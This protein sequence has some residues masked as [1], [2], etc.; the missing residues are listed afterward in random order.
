MPLRVNQ[1][2][3]FGVGR[4]GTPGSSGDAHFANVVLLCGFEGSDGST[5]LDDESASNHTLTAAGNA[6]IDTAL[7]KYGASSLLLD[8]TGDVV[9][10]PNSANFQFGSGQFTV[11]CHYRP[12]ASMASAATQYLVAL[13][14]TN[15]QRSWTLGV[16]ETAGGFKRIIFGYSTAGTSATALESN[17]LS[18]PL[19]AGGWGTSDGFVH[20]A[21][22]RDGSNQLRMYVEGV[23][24]YSQPLAV[25]LFNSTASLSIGGFLTSG[26]PA[27][28][29]L[30]GSIDE[31]R[32]TKGVAR[33]ATDSSFTP[34]ASA[35]PRS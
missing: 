19:G 4:V 28:N 1:L 13:Y 12:G 35:Y 7:F 30:N 25:T 27:G 11:E 10:A 5:T 34:P 17:T 20:V 26:A 16:S 24:V 29:Y 33:Y 21:V 18:P 31:L 32:I 9:T 2:N 14:D 6:Q 15:S 23:Q 22:D 3:G 8:G